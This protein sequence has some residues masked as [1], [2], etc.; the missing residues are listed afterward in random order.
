MI[1]PYRLQGRNIVVDTYSGG[2]HVLDNLAYSAV[3]TMQNPRFDLTNPG[4]WDDLEDKLLKEFEDKTSKEE[5]RD[6]L[7]GISEL[8]EE[9]S[10]FS[11]DTYETLSLNL[12][13]RK[14]SVKALCL[15]VAHTCNLDCDYCF[16][17]QGKY[18]GERA[19]M[20]EEVAKASIDFL[21]ENSG[22]HHN[23]DIDFFGGEP[24]MNMDVVKE[25][26]TYAKEQG[27]KHDKNFRFTF[28]TNG[29]LLDTETIDYLN[30][31]MDNVVLSLDGRK[32]I[33]DALRHTINGKGSYDVIV[34]RFQE[35]VE[36]RGDKEYYIRGTY[37]KNNKDFTQDILHMADLGFHRLS[38]EPVI[39]DSE[40]DY[41]LGPDDVKELEEQYERLAEEMIRR[42][43]KAKEMEKLGGSAD[44]LSNQDKPFIFYHYMLD[45]DGGPC[46]HKRISGCGA[47]SE[48][49]AVTPWG[50]LYPCHQ[51]VGEDDYKVGN[52]YDG[53]QEEALTKDFKECNVYS[54]PECK[55]CWAKLYCSGGCSANALHASGSIQGI[56]PF[57][58]DLFR[59]RIECALSVQV[60]E[61]LANLEDDRKA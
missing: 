47:G 21:I 33:H 53:I 25:T 17:S 1:H 3:K 48:Y 52:V 34:P 9:G 15:N 7:K 55:D 26:V 45:L 10:L 50:D 61:A 6:V 46:I 18:Q 4:H 60:E 51:F 58:C 19:L 20:S 22:G 38:M 24:L 29:M 13:D 41:L 57:S 40:D 23:L 44:D 42:N 12:R 56:V 31:T 43:G 49:M 32:E 54:H 27:E 11:N 14:T 8:I 36:K 30:D 37:T 39:G 28:T 35:F 5:V 2:V 16:A 59:K